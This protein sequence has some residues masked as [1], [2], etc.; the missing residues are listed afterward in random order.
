MTKKR[1]PKAVREFRQEMAIKQRKRT[2]EWKRKEFEAALAKEKLET[3]RDI[4]GVFCGLSH[5]AMESAACQKI[6]KLA[7]RGFNARQIIDYMEP[8]KRDSIPGGRIG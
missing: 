8:K 2:S 4:F 7:A 5:K 1:V 6:V 3:Y